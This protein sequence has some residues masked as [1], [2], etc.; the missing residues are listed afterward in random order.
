M[1]TRQVLKKSIHYR[2][3][4]NILLFAPKS[5]SLNAQPPPEYEAANFNECE[6]LHYST[7]RGGSISLN[8]SLQMLLAARIFT[9]V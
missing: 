6:R 9:L 1:E 8:R 2:I 7:A 5:K 4:Y 3:I